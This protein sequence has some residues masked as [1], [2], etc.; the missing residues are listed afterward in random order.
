VLNYMA[1]GPLGF[2]LTDVIVNFVPYVGQLRQQAIVK[3]TIEGFF[4]RM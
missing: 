1:Q 4:S 2:F 3:T